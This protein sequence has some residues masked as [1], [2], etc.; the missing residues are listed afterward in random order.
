MQKDYISLSSKV[1]ETY[2]LTIMAVNQKDLREQLCWNQQ[3][4]S[5]YGKKRSIFKRKI[6]QNTE[7]VNFSLLLIFNIY[8]NLNY[9]WIINLHNRLHKENLI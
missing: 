6:L 4:D 1:S 3:F 2:Y 9:F 8:T 5:G 7:Q